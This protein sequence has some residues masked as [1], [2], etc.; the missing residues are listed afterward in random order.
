V[1]PLCPSHG[2]G[3]LDPVKAEALLRPASAREAAALAEVRKRQAE[4]KARS[5]RQRAEAE[6][7]PR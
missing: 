5:T 7:A 3:E 2:V 1:A 4:E 6:A